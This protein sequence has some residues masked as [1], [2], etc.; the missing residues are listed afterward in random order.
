VVDVDAIELPAVKM[1][2][3]NA[4][5]ITQDIVRTTS[6]PLFIQVRILQPELRTQM[7]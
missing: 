4:I 6:E 1:K 5:E 7:R 3:Q 2:Q